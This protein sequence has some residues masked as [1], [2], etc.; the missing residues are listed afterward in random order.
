MSWIPGIFA[1]RR[2]GNTIL[3]TKLITENMGQYDKHSTYHECFVPWLVY[4]Y[5]GWVR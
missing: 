2:L 3:R 5:I 4:G 1:P